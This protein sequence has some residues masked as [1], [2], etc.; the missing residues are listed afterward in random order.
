MRYSAMA[1]SGLP[2][3]LRALPRLLWA[4]A[5][6][7]LRRIAVRYSAMASSPLPWAARASRGCCGL[8]R[9]RAEADRCAVFSDGLVVL[10]P[11]RQREAEAVVG[12]GV[13]WLE[14]DR[15]AVFGDGLIVL[16]PVRQR[17]AEVDVGFGEVGLEA[18]RGPEFG[19]SLLA[20]ALVPQG[21]AE[22][23]VGIVVLG[24][25]RTPWELGDGLVALA[26]VHQG[27]AEVDVS[28][29]E[30][31]H[32]A[33]RGAVFGNGLVV[34]AVGRQGGPR[35]LWA[36]ASWGSSGSLCGI[37]RWPRRACPGHSGQ[38]RG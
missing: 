15:G 20:V 5:S 34:L 27:D 25:S 13:V 11:G 12:S 31:G 2:C 35:L 16:A 6:S 18:D 23:V 28:F 7:G 37:Q 33:D 1:S 21:E 17:E 32:E 26:L 9:R 19:D 38:G 4:S 14:A 3:S 8:R 10:A 24:L 30:F 36:L 29:G 22:V